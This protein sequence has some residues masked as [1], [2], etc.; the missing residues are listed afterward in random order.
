MKR[1]IITLGAS[2]SVGGKIISASSSGSINGITIAL[3]GDAIFCPACRSQGKI[4]CRGPRIPETWNGKNVALEDDLCV[5]GCSTPPRLLP[6]QFVRYQFT[7][8]TESNALQ[9]NKNAANASAAANTLF[10]DRY[11]LLDEETGQILANTEYALKRADGQIEFGVTD[12]SGH[13]HLVASPMKTESIDI[14]V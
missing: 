7:S 11:L 1:H 9:P 3:E 12:E 4:L 8:E 6:S 5:C 13:T 2:T 10:D 14:Y